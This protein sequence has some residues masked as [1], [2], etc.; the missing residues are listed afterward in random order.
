MKKLR[1]CVW[2]SKYIALF[3]PGAGWMDVEIIETLW[4]VLNVVSPSTWDM[5]TPHQQELLDFQMNDSN[6]MKIICMTLSLTRKLC[7]ARESATLTVFVFNDLDAT[8]SSEK[9]QQWESEKR[10][11]QE[12]WLMEPSAMDILEVQLQ[13]GELLGLNCLPQF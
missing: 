3:I 9:R 7:K 5:T 11:A 1:S 6:F 13:N 2:Q 10:K 4:L 8:V 12:Q